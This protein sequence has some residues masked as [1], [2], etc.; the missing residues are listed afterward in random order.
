VN[1]LGKLHILYF[2]LCL[3]FSLLV[4]NSLQFERFTAEVFGL[5]LPFVVKVIVFL[6]SLVL[7]YYGSSDTEI[8]Y[9]TLCYYTLLYVFLFPQ[10]ENGHVCEYSTVISEQIISGQTCNYM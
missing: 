7:K 1:F 10:Y 5:I 8:K 4:F 3:I 9:F 2:H 6:Q